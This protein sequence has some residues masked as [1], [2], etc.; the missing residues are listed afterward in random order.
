MISDAVS[1]IFFQ[2]KDNDQVA[3]GF[4]KIKLPGTLVQVISEA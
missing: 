4:E 2:K 3:N 1:A